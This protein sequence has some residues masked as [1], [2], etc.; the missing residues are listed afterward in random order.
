MKVFLYEINELEVIW[1]DSEPLFFRQTDTFSIVAVL[2]LLRLKGQVSHLGQCFISLTLHSPIEAASDWGQTS[3]FL[4]NL[5][6]GCRLFFHFYWSHLKQRTQVRPND[7]K[8]FFSSSFFNRKCPCPVEPFL[9]SISK[10]W[11][12]PRASLGVGVEVWNIEQC[13]SSLHFCL[14]LLDEDRR[15]NE[16]VT[17]KVF[18]LI[19]GQLLL[20]ICHFRW[21]RGRNIATIW[22][23]M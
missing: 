8:A 5:N 20:M 12:E 15:R 23:K 17:H 10:G 14:P 2:S 4:Q 6:G 13:W 18:A 3:F 1:N 16:S 19:A 11:N 7:E 9:C 21:L 22:N